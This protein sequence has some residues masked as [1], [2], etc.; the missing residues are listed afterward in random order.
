MATR[1]ITNSARIFIIDLAFEDIAVRIDIFVED[2]IYDGDL[3]GYDM[4]SDEHRLS[5]RMP[6]I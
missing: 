6:L 5:I 4:I 2:G 3:T 1:S